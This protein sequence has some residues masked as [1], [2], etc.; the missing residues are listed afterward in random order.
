[1]QSDEVVEA[2]ARAIC[3]PDPTDCLANAIVPN[4][5]CS[6]YMDEARAAITAHD[7]ALKRQVETLR[8]AVGKAVAFL[9]SAPLE[10]GY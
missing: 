3:C 9:D 8:E 2:V 10:S 1:M 6:E 4:C 5:R 7:T